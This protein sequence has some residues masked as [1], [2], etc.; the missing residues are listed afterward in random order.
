MVAPWAK[1]QPELPPH[2]NFAQG[3]NPDNRRDD[4]PPI[5]PPSYLFPRESLEPRIERN[6]FFQSSRYP[7]P[8]W[9]SPRPVPVSPRETPDTPRITTT[10]SLT[11]DYLDRINN[12]VSRIENNITQPHSFR[13]SPTASIVRPTRSSSQTSRRF[14]L[15]RNYETDDNIGDNN[16]IIETSEDEL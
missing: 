1:R 7:S 4:F 9:E 8:P 11:D 13:R 14:P 3:R 15:I 6:S 10:S 5:Q 12:M 2:Y 16:S